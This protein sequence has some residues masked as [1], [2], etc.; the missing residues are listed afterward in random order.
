MLGAEDLSHNDMAEI[1]SEV[2]EQPVRFQQIGGEAFTARL[3]GFGMSEAMAQGMLDMMLAKNEGPRQ[4]RAPDA[5]VH[6]RHEL[7]AVV[8]GRAAAGRP[9]VSETSRARPRASRLP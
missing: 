4:R 8:R 6:H 3:T 7:P 1:M 9:G 2:L 5:A